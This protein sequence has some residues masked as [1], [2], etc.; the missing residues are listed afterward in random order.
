[1]K[2]VGLL[3]GLAALLGAGSSSEKSGWMESFD[4]FK[5]YPYRSWPSD[6]TKI[7][8][9]PWQG[10][11]D[12]YA[13]ADTGHNTPAG[14]AGPVFNWSWGHAFRPTVDTPHV[15]DELVAKIFLPGNVNYENV[16]LAIT[17]KKTPGAAGQFAGGAKA[18]IHIGAS[19]DKRFARI[20]FRTTDKADKTL[21]QVSA[22]PHPFLPAGVWY[23]VRLA[24]DE[25]R[26]VTAA[27]KHEKMSYWVPIGSLAAHDDFQPNYAAI[28]VSR[29]GRLDDV[30]YSATHRRGV[31]FAP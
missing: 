13:H 29:G 30:G 26:T 7:L 8:P 19:R 22:A 21:S 14:A 10:S 4:K 20:S 2:R 5:D 25:N 18:V 31:L 23:D 28:A 17:T 6:G 1:M 9:A 11:V 24:L 15:G 3:L 16:M 12:M 27:Y